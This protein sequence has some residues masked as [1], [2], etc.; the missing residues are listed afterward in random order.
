MP[1]TPSRQQVNIT[2]KRELFEEILKHSSQISLGR[3]KHISPS[4]LI[5]EVLDNHFKTK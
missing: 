2:L 4:K 5:V 3:K 1:N